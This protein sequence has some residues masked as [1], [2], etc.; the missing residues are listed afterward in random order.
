M[1][2]PSF[3]E[4]T[5]ELQSGA[6]KRF[7]ALTNN[8]PAALPAFHDW[9]DVFAHAA[10]RKFSPHCRYLSTE[11]FRTSRILRGA[12]DA[13]IAGFHPD[14]ALVLVSGTEYEDGGV[15][16]DPAETA[17]NL[18]AIGRTLRT[19]GCVP[20]FMTY[21]GIDDHGNPPEVL[22]HVRG[23]MERV[24]QAAAD[25][26]AG[27]I[28]HTR[29]WDRLQQCYPALYRSLM[30]DPLHANPEGYTLMGVDIVRAFGAPLDRGLSPQLD[31]V[32]AL[33][34]LLDAIAE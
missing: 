33:Q 2:N 27:L 17:D 21:Y 20:V 14:V 16:F 9:F 10:R 13:E 24:R 6:A 7:L 31:R 4:L 12:L 19:A 1:K 34:E 11:Y 8:G 18:H 3:T 5:A 23:N 22:R 28:D 15:P 32:L 25:C 26:G 30:A 29:R